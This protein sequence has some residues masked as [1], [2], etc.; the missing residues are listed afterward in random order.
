MGLGQ[1][2]RTKNAFL[3]KLYCDSHHS[4]SF[5]FFMKYHYPPNLKFM[6]FQLSL[7]ILT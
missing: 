4:H 5:L 2:I 6:L 1:N 3:P 7:V